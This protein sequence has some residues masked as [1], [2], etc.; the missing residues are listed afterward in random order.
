MKRFKH[1]IIAVY[2]NSAFLL[3][4]VLTFIAIE[5]ISTILMKVAKTSVVK[6]IVVGVT[7]RANDSIQYYRSLPYY[8]NQEW[9]GQYWQEHKA[10]LKKNYHPYVIWRSPPLKV[11]C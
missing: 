8:S 2:R 6:G 7:G 3:N 1:F 9:S 11:K 5:L 10:A 4:I